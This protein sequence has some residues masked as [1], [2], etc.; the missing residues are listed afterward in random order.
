MITPFSR[1]AALI[2]AELTSRGI[3]TV[4]VGTVH[5]LQGAQRRVILFS[6]VY[7]STE[8]FA[9]FINRSANMMNV[10]VSR[11]QDAFLV[12]GDMGIFEPKNHGTPTGLMARYLFADEANE[13]RSLRY[14]LRVKIASGVTIAHLSTLDQH[15]DTLLTSLRQAKRQVLIVS[16]YLSVHALQANDL[17]RL[18]RNRSR[19]IQIH[20]YTDD[21]LNRGRD[22]VFKPS[23]RKAKES[24]EQIG[25]NLI[26]G[27][28]IHS[29]TLCM[30][31]ELLVEG[32]FNW[33]GAIR[34]MDHPW[35]R[36]ETSLCYRGPGIAPTLRTVVEALALRARRLQ[37]GE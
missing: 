1:Q 13:I 23:A 37:D 26:F 36:L 12:F 7:D 28:G 9:P 5:R 8:L 14:P 30:D 24:L 2:S 18:L 10:A 6:P 35:Q 31:D 32:S 15:I 19:E 3:S 20:I 33:L 27:D 34:D 11:A 29:K 22:G 4:T 17:E 25:T 16:P 21:Y